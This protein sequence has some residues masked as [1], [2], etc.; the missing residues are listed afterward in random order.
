MIVIK[1]SKEIEL[2]QESGRIVALAHEEIKKAIK[3]GITT[4]ELDEIA[5]AIIR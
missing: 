1:T 3:P 2:M 5:E 4:G